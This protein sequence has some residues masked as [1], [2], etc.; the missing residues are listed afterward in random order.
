MYQETCPVTDGPAPPEILDVSDEIL[1]DLSRQVAQFVHHPATGQER[2]S[3][4]R[5]A[6]PRLIPLSPL[7]E[8]EEAS[9]RPTIHV[10]GKHL[11]PL[12][13]DFYHRE[14]LPERYAIASLQHSDDRWVHFLMK[15]TWCRF[16]RPG[17]Y[18]SGGRFIQLVQ[19]QGPTPRKGT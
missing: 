7:P 9:P 3:D 19:W 5:I 1:R 2:R 4:R 17:W 12:G 10:I 13:L 11:A 6:Y 15:I 14:P 8:T 18:D 16:L